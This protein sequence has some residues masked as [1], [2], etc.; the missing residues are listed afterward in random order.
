[1]ETTDKTCY[2]YVLDT[3]ADWEIGYITAELSSGR[4]LDKSRETLSLVK[5]GN[6]LKPV[7]TMGG[8][9]ITPDVGIEKI[10]FK[11][12]DILLL[13]GA[14][15]WFEEEQRK[16]IDMTAALLDKNVVIAAICGATA[17]LA[18]K[19]LLN[20][21]KHTSND[22]VYL[23]MVGPQ[24]R[25]EDYYSNL[26]AVVD[27]NLVTATGLAPLEF[28]YE[29]FKTAR[30]MKESTLDAWYNLNKTREPQYFYSLM[31]SIQ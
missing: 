17:A 13:P 22:K 8:M 2:L 30:V 6:S 15:T 5:I 28:S 26:P 31:Q 21:R 23:K 16:V 20:E 1:M 25:G 7:I 18:S 27:G 11:D 24:Y 19:G 4:Y 12:G 10:D 14:D 29:L 3:L 9:L